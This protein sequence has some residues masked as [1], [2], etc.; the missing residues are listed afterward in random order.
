MSSS[1]EIDASAIPTARPATAR[2]AL[3]RSSFVNEDGSPITPPALTGTLI[4][5][6]PLAETQR[7][8]LRTTMAIIADTML[9]TERK[10]RQRLET[11][12]RLDGTYD[13]PDDVDPSTG[14][15]KTKLFIPNNIRKQKCP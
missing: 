6:K 10:T 7:N 13:D 14:K 12:S 8:E 4:H 3:P 5:I 9:K 1:T 15:G 2:T 11:R